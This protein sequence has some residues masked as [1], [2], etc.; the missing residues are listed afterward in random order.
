MTVCLLALAASGG[1]ATT[2]PHPKTATVAGAKP[3]AGGP[4]AEGESART[5]HRRPSVA[6]LKARLD[7][8]LDEQDIHKRVAMLA[9]VYQDLPEGT[10]VRAFVAGLL[11]QDYAS[12]GKLDEMRKVAREVPLGEDMATAD[13]LNAMA[14]AYAEAGKHLT[15]AYVRVDQA[16][17]ILDHL[18]HK[19]D[20]LT[21]AGQRRAMKTRR[22]AYLDT[23]GWVL[24]KLGELDDAVSALT[25]AA[26]LLDQ[27]EIHTH[28]GVAL[29]KQGKIQLA[30]QH[31]ARAVA[32]GG[33]G[34]AAAK[35]ALEK[36]RGKVD[37]DKLIDE[38]KKKVEAAHQARRKA[39]RA[40]VLGQAMDEPLP[41]FAATDLTGSAIDTSKLGQGRIAVVWFW[42]TWCQPCL[43]EMP[44]LQALY[45]R[46]RNDPGVRFLGLSV[47]SSAR[48]ARRYL[49]ARGVDL[50][51]GHA[52][53]DGVGDALGIQ[54]IPLLLVIGPDGRIRYRHLGFDPRLEGTLR[55]EI[56]ALRT[57]SKTKAAAAH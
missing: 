2:T 47:D 43:E 17:R 56:E 30:A 24:V 13:L 48:I 26:K 20:E 18:E 51:M 11:A 8:A 40:H 14:Y 25:R 42:A 41:K 44:R 12:L 3:A 57:S 45:Q 1:C 55:M 52:S 6:E 50:P 10:G 28:L 31:F 38:A 54:A 39:M 46:Y 22:G 29:E 16:I 36:L 37:V 33:D 35:A 23:E 4:G 21:T 5:P 15:E 34:A 53:F 9:S 27:S 49:A 32:L 7:A 19:A